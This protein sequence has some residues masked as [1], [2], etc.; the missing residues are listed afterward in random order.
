MRTAIAAAL[1]LAAACGD[2]GND[3]DP[4]RQ[5]VAGER[6]G[7][8]AL[9]MHWSEVVA[10]IGRPPAEP[11]VLVRVGHATW[12]ALGLEA[13][14]TSPDEASITDDAIIIGAGATPGADLDGPVLPGD[15]RAGIETSIGAPPEEYGGRVYYPAGLAIEYDDTGR[16][17]RVGVV[18]PYTL[19]PAPPPMQPATEAP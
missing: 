16:A 7:P 9:G 5:L 8:I 10:A 2:A 1:A 13:L 12:P 4:R 11:L 19:A 15:P 6:V 14:V 18:A 3:A 17:R